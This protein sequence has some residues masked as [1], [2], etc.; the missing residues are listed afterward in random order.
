MKLKLKILF[1]FFIISLMV[2]GE[3]FHSKLKFYHLTNSNGLSQNTI[4]CILQDKT[5]FIWIGTN[6]GLN[7]WNGYNFIN[8]IHSKN[9]STSIG[10]GRINHIYEDDTGKIWIGTFQGGLSLYDEKNDR[11]IRYYNNTNKLNPSSCNNITQIVEYDEWLILGTFGSGLFIFDRLNNYFKHLPIFIN[12]KNEGHNLSVQKLFVES[13]SIIWVGHANGLIKINS[14]KHELNEH[15]AWGINVINNQSILSVHKYHNQII[16]GSENRGIYYYNSAKQEVQ[17]NNHLFSANELNNLT[18]RDFIE[19]KYGNLWIAS[20]SKGVYIYNKSSGTFTNYS[21]LQN[22][23]TTLTSDI[24]YCFAMDKNSNIWVGTFN[25]GV[26]FANYSKQRFNHIRG[27]GQSNE[28]NNNA[29]LSFCELKESDILIGTDGGGLSIYNTNNQTIDEFTEIPDLINIGV[30][31]CFD[32]DSVGNIYIGTYKNGLYVYNSIN[33]TVK[34]YKKGNTSNQLLS[35]NI[36]AIEVANNNEV[37][38]GTLGNGISKF[39]PKKGDFINFYNVTGDTN[40]L[41]NNFISN[42]CATSDG[43]IWIATHHAGINILLDKTHG[44]FKRLSSELNIGLTSN[45]VWDIFEDSKNNIWVATHDGGLCFYDNYSKQFNAFTTDNGLPSNNIR[46]IIEDKNNTLWLSTN[47]GLSKISIVTEKKHFTNFSIKHGLQGNEFN[48]NASLITS[49]NYLIFGGNNGFNIFNP[50]SIQFSTIDAPTVITN[51]SVLYHNMKSKGN[52]KTLKN[53]HANT[54]HITL[55]YDLSLLSIE[56]ALLDYTFTESNQ[57]YYKLEGYNNDWIDNNTSRK[58]SFTNLDA[59]EY[60]LKIKGTN[61]FGIQFGNVATLKISILPPFW[62]KLWFKISSIIFLIAAV[63]VIYL[64][65]IK[66]YRNQQKQLEISVNERTKKLL[67]LNEL[68]S[69]KNNEIELQSE[70]L[71]TQREQLLDINNTLETSN[72][73][74]ENQNTELEK[75]RNNLESLVKERT[76]DLENA[77]IKAEE[78]EQLKMAFLANMSHEIR[79]PLNAIVGFSSLIT[80]DFYDTEERNKFASLIN[81]NSNSLLVLIDD[82]LDLSKI[83]ANQLTIKRKEF[84]VISLLSEIYSH[85]KFIKSTELKYIAFTYE[86]KSE[87]KILNLLSDQNRIKQIVDNLIDNAFK[88]TCEG[89]IVLRIK[90]NNNKLIIEVED[91]GIGIDSK[92]LNTIFDRFRKNENDGDKTYR[93]A[94]LGLTIS[95]KLATL[96][97]GNISVESVSG[98][99]SIFRLLLALNEN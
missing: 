75:H 33:K 20:E 49:G 84:D 96:L 9:D 58:I 62:E 28:L 90:R 47:K 71:K 76:T 34:H 38:I 22:N 35:N 77:K 93:G 13:D 1:S 83:E 97:K 32:K 37:W 42:I 65:R 7:K 45:E 6:G 68:L 63:R 11:F 92:N 88:F 85:W 57:Y 43:Q 55:N 67:D 40:S 99:G 64:L 26:N 25:G 15:K 66:A 61:N 44:K 46:A 17:T 41:S 18:I 19:D 59:G 4:N 31:V 23:P 27:Y 89:K 73:R 87:L 94:G 52:I 81:T 39:N 78:S 30:V 95:K 86:N 21:S 69:S 8:Y 36:W 53:I 54:E 2:N 3:N 82:I 98:K 91:T 10:Q 50:D 5:G 79:T 56:F 74:I 80:D 14:I 24:I 51:I 12:S 16:I 48:S 29:I 72:K 70:E 60:T